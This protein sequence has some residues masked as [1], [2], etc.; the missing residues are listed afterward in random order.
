[1]IKQR[2]ERRVLRSIWLTAAVEMVIL[3]DLKS[4]REAFRNALR[5]NPPQ[6]W[7]SGVDLYS[8]EEANG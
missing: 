2:L 8:V 6:K 4:S 5:R 7:Q 1:M 3:R